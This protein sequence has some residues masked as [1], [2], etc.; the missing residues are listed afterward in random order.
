MTKRVFALLLALG[1][2]LSLGACGEKARPSSQAPTE[3]SS[4]EVR[5]GGPESSAP[6]G[7]A[8]SEAPASGIPQA[9]DALAR[10]IVMVYGAEET[11]R[12]GQTLLVPTLVSLYF[13]SDPENSWEGGESLDPWSYFCWVFGST[14]KEEY[15]Y[16]LE[17]YKNPKG[18]EYGWFFPQDIY[19]ERVQT[20]FEVSTGHLRGTDAY[21]AEYQG[22]SIGGGGGRGDTP[23]LSYE[24]SQ[25]GELLT[26]AVT[27]DYDSSPDCRHTLTVRLEEG[28]GW[29]YLADKVESLG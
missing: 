19:E 5:S 27:A 6:E 26:I 3:P 18:E 9:D 12:D 29:K 21:D 4:I 24:Y 1:L 7:E 23:V 20:Y 10:E 22:Y 17:A 14:M 25:E 8:S 2:A 28:G 11:V 13:S 16:K 15:E